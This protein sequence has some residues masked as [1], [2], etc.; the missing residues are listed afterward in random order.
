VAAGADCVYPILL[1]DKGAI[2]SF[3]ESVAAPVNI[4]ALPA[5]PSIGRLAQLGV[6]RV[7]YGPL[8]HRQALEHLAGLLAAIERPPS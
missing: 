6:A 8:L 4:L 5:A 7:S 2:A 3:V 1:H